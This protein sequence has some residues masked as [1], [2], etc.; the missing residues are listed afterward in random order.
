MHSLGCRLKWNASAE[1][2]RCI[3]CVS[4]WA[5]WAKYI[6]RYIECH[7]VYFHAHRCNTRWFLRFVLVKYII[8]ICSMSMSHCKRWNDIKYSVQCRYQH[9]VIVSLPAC[10]WAVINFRYCR[11]MKAKTATKLFSWTIPLNKQQP[12]L[13][14]TLIVPFAH[15]FGFCT[16]CESRYLHQCEI[17]R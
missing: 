6:S 10:I 9:V 1:K 15:I 12:V 3:L 4:V 11:F 17:I 8:C 2:L 7:A 13:I 14:C 16:T 5:D